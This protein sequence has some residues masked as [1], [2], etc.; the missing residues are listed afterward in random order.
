MRSPLLISKETSWS[1]F[2]PSA[3]YRADSFSTRRVP[4]VGQ[5]AGGAPPSVGLGSCS[6][7]MYWSMR[8]RLLA[9]TIDDV[10]ERSSKI[11]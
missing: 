11:K 2:G 7:L 5:Y 10:S 4:L 3:E 9:S 8:S 6:F 1:T